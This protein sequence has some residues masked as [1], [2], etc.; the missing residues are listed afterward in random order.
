MKSWCA[1]SL[2]GLFL[3]FCGCGAAIPHAQTEVLEGIP[4]HLEVA[5]FAGGCFWCLES[6]FSKLPA[7]KQVVSGYAGGQES[8]PTYRQVTSGATGHV[9]AIRIA[10][11]P[12]AITYREVLDY[13]WR[14]IDPTDDG[15]QFADRGAH[16]RTAVF[17]HSPEQR[18][19]AEESQRALDASGRFDRPVATEIKPFTTFYPAEAYHQQYAQRNRA[20]YTR[21]RQGSGRDRFLETVWGQGPAAPPGTSEAER[22]SRPDD[23]TLRDTLTPMQYRVTQGNATEPPFLNAYWNNKE[24][25]IYVDIVS[26]EPLFSTLDQFDSGTGWPSFTKPLIPER[27]VEREDRSG[28]MVRTEVRSLGADS[29]LGHVFCDD[30]DATEMRYCIN[31]AALRFIPAAELEQEGYGAFVPLFRPEQDR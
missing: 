9:E 3:L 21:Y 1:V 15:G 20:A 7:V 28:G 17:Y 25:G 22:Y 31:S 12:Q 10:F 19:Q 30:P 16:Y 18:Q 29:H 14:H 24:P 6:D 23:A 11:D 26:G 2:A 13:F 5:T 27:M 4:G 8:Q